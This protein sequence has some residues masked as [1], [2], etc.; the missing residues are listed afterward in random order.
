[1]SWWFSGWLSEQAEG[2][3][4]IIP[5]GDIAVN[6]DF[7]LAD[8]VQR[9]WMYRVIADVT[10][11]A[12]APYTNTGQSFKDGDEIY[13]LGSLWG[14]IGADP[15]WYDDGAGD[16]KKLTPGN[17]VDISGADVFTNNIKS[18]TGNFGI[19][20]IDN[21]KVGVFGYDM[22]NALFNRSLNIKDAT[23]GWIGFET[24]TGNQE[25]HIIEQDGSGNFGF[26]IAET[27]VANRFFIEPGGNI[28]I[29][30]TAPAENLVVSASGTDTTIQIQRTDTIATGHRT[31]LEFKHTS[32]LLGRVQSYLPGNLDVDLRFYTTNNNA[33]NTTP[34]LTLTGNNDVGIGIDSPTKKL[35]VAGDT[36]IVGSDNN[37]TL[38][39]LIVQSGSQQMLLDGNEIDAMDG[40]LYFQANST[41]NTIFN[42]NGGSVGI[43][44]ISPNSSL[45]V[46]GSQSGK[47][48]ASAVDYNPS[49]LTTD[50]LIVIT[51]T[52]VQRA[53]TISTEDIQSGTPANPRFFIV[54]D[55]SGGAGTNRIRVSGETGTINGAS[56]IDM[57]SPYYSIILYADGT[58]LWAIL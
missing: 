19:E 13:W 1:M 35:H 4:A 20:V 12:G 55:E 46:N 36:L 58:N 27:G 51:D 7:P 43:G 28:G 39:A 41:N 40:P 6:T 2:Q 38:A 48:T 45:T 23:N 57:T 17:N 8:Q 47:R 50:Y 9:G 24:S 52:S 54:F 26:T 44:T 31:T 53:V 15:V 3:D 25:W 10:D 18:G 30:T 49:I 22:T 5:K 14:I 56:Y 33:I 29:G 16:I 11:N 37:G 21:G 34:A 32:T 42:N